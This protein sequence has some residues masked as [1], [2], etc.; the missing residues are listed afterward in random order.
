MELSSCSL[1][2]ANDPMAMVEV[3]EATPSSP[4]PALS[5]IAMEFA[6]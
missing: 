6:P 4:P 1:Y 2:P 5:P 3:S